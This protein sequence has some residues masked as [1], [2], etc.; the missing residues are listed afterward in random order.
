VSEKQRVLDRVAA[1][2]QVTIA[3]PYFFKSIGLVLDE[4][5]RLQGLGQHLERLNDNLDITSGSVSVLVDTLHNSALDANHILATQL[6]SNL[7][8]LQAASFMVRMLH[9]ALGDA[10]SVTQIDKHKGGVHASLLHPTTEGDLGSGIGKTESVTGVS[11]HVRL[12]V[13]TLAI[14]HLLLLSWVKK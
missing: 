1:D 8:D 9:H 10:V 3:Q 7:V 2:V 4:H 12:N 6:G 11:S 5:G 13:G 14:R